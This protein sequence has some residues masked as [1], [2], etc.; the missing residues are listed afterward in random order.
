MGNGMD[1]L[2]STFDPASLFDWIQ[3][4]GI[5]GLLAFIIIGGSRKWWVFGWQYKDLQDRCEKIESS[6]AM[7]MQLAL[8]GVNVTEK[9][10]ETNVAPPSG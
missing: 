3:S 1:L 5:I 7:W 10:V 2:S 4:G 9:L 6:N 8:R